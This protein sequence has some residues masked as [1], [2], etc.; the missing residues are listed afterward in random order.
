MHK[1]PWVIGELIRAFRLEKGL[2][3]RQL[4][5]RSDGAFRERDVLRIEQGRQG[6][7]RPERLRLLLQTLDMDVMSLHQGGPGGTPATLRALAQIPVA[8][9]TD[10]MFVLATARERLQLAMTQSQLT[11]QRTT[12]LLSA[13]QQI[14]R[15]RAPEPLWAAT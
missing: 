13:S 3:L 6:N 12:E 1:Q 11:C 15:A 5:D 10:P 7:L 9:R 2:T 4:A 14:A 8:P